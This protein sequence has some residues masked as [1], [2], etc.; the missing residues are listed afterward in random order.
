MASEE[1][2]A[3]RPT[4][5][6][7][8]AAAGV[9]LSTASRALGAGTHVSAPTRERVWAAAERL[10]FEP[11][12]LAR[13]LR[14]GS[15]M[16]V[17]LVIPDVAATFY[18]TALKGVQEVLEAAGY[19]V[20]VVNTGRAAGRERE[21]IRS[22]RAHQVD[23][24]IIATYGGYEDIGVPAVFFDDVLPDVGVGAIALANADGIA[25][26]VDHLVQEH[27]QRRIAYVGPPDTSGDGRT[28]GVFTAR[29]RLDGF[30][31]AAGRAGLPLP[32]EYIRFADPLHGAT[33]AR[34]A[35]IELLAL[36]EPPTSVVG[37]TDTLAMGL[38]QAARA[39]GV[40]VPE[41]LAIVSFDEPPYADLLEP[42][43]TS[44]DRHDHELGRRAADLLLAAL[45]GTGPAASAAPAVQRVPVE[46]RV[47]RSCGCAA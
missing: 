40:R 2:T 22:L 39:C 19:H 28:P 1:R 31:A 12:Q 27:G 26:L 29:E 23:G 33:A 3:R 7:V 16:A 18:G 11:N 6:D 41:D 34:T 13:S 32:P 21:A 10:R 15:T 20:L 43:I 4:L 25:L 46:L 35:G 45:N 47:R 37:A 38:L 14:R 17:G 44:L 24:L 9:S 30:R 5:A 42:P 36:D 8:A